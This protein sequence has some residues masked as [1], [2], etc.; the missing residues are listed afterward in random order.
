MEFCPEVAKEIARI[1][2]ALSH[3]GRIIILTSLGKLSL[4]DIAKQTGLSFQALQRHVHELLDQGLITKGK[5][6]GE[7]C[8]TEDGR[9]TLN[10]LKVFTKIPTVK[11]RVIAVS[12]ERFKEALVRYR[13]ELTKEEMIRIFEN[14][15]KER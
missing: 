3:E 1:N 4:S 15:E 5:T 10:A 14:L 8:L 13:S 6:K 7:Y 11:R 2:K 9:L 12:K